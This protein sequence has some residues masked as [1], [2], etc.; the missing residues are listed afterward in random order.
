MNELSLFLTITFPFTET[1][2]KTLKVPAKTVSTACWKF[3]TSCDP[4]L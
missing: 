2:Y 1:F 3:V 4:Q